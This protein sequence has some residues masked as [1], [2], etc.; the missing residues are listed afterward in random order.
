MHN[1][2]YFEKIYH[3]AIFNFKDIFPVI[4]LGEE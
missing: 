4:L 2:E 1:P 3:A